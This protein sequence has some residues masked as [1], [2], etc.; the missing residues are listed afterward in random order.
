MPQQGTLPQIMVTSKQINDNYHLC[1]VCCV[2]GNLH[3]GL[4]LTHNTLSDVISSVV[5]MADQDAL[6]LVYFV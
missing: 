3:I 1:R 5:P 2:P 4:T 6:L